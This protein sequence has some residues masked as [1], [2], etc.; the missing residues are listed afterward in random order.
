[1]KIRKSL[2][3][4]GLLGGAVVFSTFLAPNAIM[5]AQAANCGTIP[6]NLPVTFCDPDRSTSNIVVSSHL[7]SEAVR[8]ALFSRYVDLAGQ[9]GVV[10]ALGFAAETAEE[11]PE[12]LSDFDAAAQSVPIWNAWVDASGVYSDRTSATAGFQGTVGLGSVGLDAALG[13]GGTVVGG[14]ASVGT[15]SY[16]T[17]S[18]FGPGTARD[19]NAGI[20]AYVGQLIG[21]SLFANAVVQYTRANNNF[22]VAATGGTYATDALSVAGSLT[23]F[24]QFDY[25]RLS[26]SATLNYATVWQDGYTE[27]SGFVSPA[28]RTDV[29]TLSVGTEA[30]YTFVNDNGQ[31]IEPWIGAGVDV[32]LYSSTTPAI[33]ASPDPLGNVNTKIS[34]GFNAFLSDTVSLSVR[35]DIGGLTTPNYMTYGL[36]GQL[37]ARF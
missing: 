31:A 14:F 12:A 7:A 17:Q 24:Y 36:G 37:S 13:D 8:K 11:A 26:P 16:N 6:G 2:G 25:F 32:T 3:L 23:G 33:P 22:S 15:S 18:A 4:C 27:I 35:G 30:G 5:P 19:D 1:M 34:G 10:E 21:D 28:R 29:A 9:P 20:G